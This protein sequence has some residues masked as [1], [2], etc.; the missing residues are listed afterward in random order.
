MDSRFSNSEKRIRRALAALD[1]AVQAW[2]AEHNPKNKEHYA[3]TSF[4]DDSESG[5]HISR[6][7]LNSDPEGKSFIDIRSSKH[8]YEV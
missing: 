3:S 5:T 8:H 1:S 2:Y 6:I 4:I 7:T